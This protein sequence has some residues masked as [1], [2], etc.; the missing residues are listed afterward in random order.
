[1]VF[2]NNKHVV[3]KL[4]QLIYVSHTQE[5]TT[6]ED[7]LSI[8][9]ISR[10]NNSRDNISGLLIYDKEIFLQ[11]LEGDRSAVERCYERIIRD[12]RHG[13]PY[14]VW[15]GDLKKRLFP[16][17]SMGYCTPSDLNDDDKKSLLALTNLIAKDVRSVGSDLL[18]SVLVRVFFGGPKVK[19][20][21]N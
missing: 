21:C 19:V 3:N 18:I 11:A 8:L 6:L 12:A 17:W 20:I 13:A 14:I 4:S 7:I 2:K 9:K 16:M 10:Y 1:M 15:Q 5:D